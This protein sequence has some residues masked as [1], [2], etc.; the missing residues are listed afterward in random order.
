VLQSSQMTNGNLPHAKII[1]NPAA[2]ACSTR[3]KWPFIQRLL[4][5]IGLSFDYQ[6][7]EGK[8]HAIELAKDAANNGYDYLVSV[9]G[10]G[11]AHEVAN[12][13][14]STGNAGHIALGVISTGTGSD[15]I[16]SIGVPKDY[17]SACHCLIDPKR[18]VIDVGIVEYQRNGQPARRFFIN[19]ADVGFDAE[20]VKYTEHMPK[21]LGGTV[22][23]VIGLLWS[24]LGYHNK[25]FLIRV[26][27]KMWNAR[28]LTAVVANGGFQGGG[29]HVAPEAKID[30]NLFDVMVVG[31][32]GKFELL[33]AFPMVYK[34]THLSHPKVRLEKGTDVSIE[35]SEP[36]L[37]H[38]DGEL[39]GDG[40]AFFHIVPKALTI[41][42]NTE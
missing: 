39:L 15:L 41:I 6:F 19:L 20:V 17:E 22:P 37:V 13:I 38:A 42:G 40:P 31:D 26:G 7:T 2:G 11:T 9:G 25:P 30:D 32:V 29:M 35:S 24:L 3:R 1:V 36:F 28:V 8:G 12:G 16:R 4:R 18:K 14:L 10:D 21:N 27:N 33:K 5:H 23:Y 34:G